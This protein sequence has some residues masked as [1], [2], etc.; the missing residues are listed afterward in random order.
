MCWEEEQKDELSHLAL[1]L[2]G[3]CFK[4]SWLMPPS[5]SCRR[6][7]ILLYLFLSRSEESKMAIARFGL[8]VQKVRT[9]RVIHPTSCIADRKPDLGNQTSEVHKWSTSRFLLASTAA[10]SPIY[11]PQGNQIITPSIAS[12]FYLAE[13]KALGLLP[14]MTLDAHIL[15]SFDFITG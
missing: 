1:S 7:P 13:V 11:P 15:P 5:C 14:D 3:R 8:V 6:K 9:R 4:A 2:E 10:V 12:K